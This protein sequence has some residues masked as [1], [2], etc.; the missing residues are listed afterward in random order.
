MSTRNTNIEAPPR[1]HSTLYTVF[2]AI[3]T[4][5][6]V[7]GVF[8]TSLPFL[9]MVVMGVEGLANESQTTSQVVLASIFSFLPKLLLVFVGIAILRRNPKAMWLTAVAFL[10]AVWDTA[11]QFLAVYP[12]ATASKSPDES[13]GFYL[14]VYAYNFF[15]LSLFVAIFSLLRAKSTRLHFQKRLEPAAAS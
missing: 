3:V 8:L 2:G 5:L 15:A 7:I 12:Q 4:T 13:F 11:F 9:Y 14:G 1:T 6:G 10:L